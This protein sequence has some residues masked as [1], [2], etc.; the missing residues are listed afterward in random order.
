[1][2]LVIRMANCWLEDQDQFFFLEYKSN[3]R[4]ML[5]TK[6]I[7]VAGGYA[8]SGKILRKYILLNCVCLRTF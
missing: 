7:S 2:F 3:C 6:C 4:D 1:M 8:E 5:Y